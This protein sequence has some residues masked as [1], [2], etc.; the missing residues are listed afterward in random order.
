MLVCY[1]SSQI[2]RP[3]IRGRR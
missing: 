2:K 1:Q 3:H